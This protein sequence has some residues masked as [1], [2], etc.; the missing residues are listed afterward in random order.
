MKSMISK[1]SAKIFVKILIIALALS[2]HKR[3]TL[4]AVPDRTTITSDTLIDKGKSVKMA[5]E[6]D[7]D[8]IATP[9]QDIPDSMIAKKN[10]S[11]TISVAAKK[12]KRKPRVNP[13]HSEENDSE[14]TRCYS[15]KGNAINSRDARDCAEYHWR[16]ASA[17]LRDLND[18]DSA[19]MHCNK[20]LR[21]YENGSL[22]TLKAEILMKITRYAQA[23][24]AAERSI[25]R[26]DHW[27]REDRFEAFRIRYK[28]YKELYR[29]YPSSESL[30][31]MES[32]KNELAHEFGKVVQ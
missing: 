8:S 26:N 28:A 31:N 9:G 16:M 2:C 20:A 17:I 21:L 3:D 6:I 4:E 25:A 32:A 13:D 18:I 5:G 10:E 30:R 19:Y 22:F 11:D 1:K 27:N 24:M 7:F 29:M 23:G 14:M 15:M 12:K